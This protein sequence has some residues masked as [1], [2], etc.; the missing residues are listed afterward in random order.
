MLLII[1]YFFS[2]GSLG[3]NKAE[4]IVSNIYVHDVTLRGTTNGLRIKSWQV[5]IIW[6]PNNYYLLLSFTFI[7]L[8][9]NF[10]RK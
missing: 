2:I 5:Y 6:F 4:D 10:T 8:K 9:K 3:K 1:F 7:F